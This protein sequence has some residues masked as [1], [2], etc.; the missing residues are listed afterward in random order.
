MLTLEQVR[1]QIRSDQR[2]VFGVCHL[3]SISDRGEKRVSLKISDSKPRACRSRFQ[4]PGTFARKKKKKEKCQA[5]KTVGLILT[6]DQDYKHP[7]DRDTWCIV[8]IHTAFTRFLIGTLLLFM[9]RVTW[10]SGRW[11]Q[12]QKHKSLNICCISS[13]LMM[14]NVVMWQWGLS[15]IKSD[16]EK[17]DANASCVHSI[18]KT[19]AG[20][21]FCQRRVMNIKNSTWQARRRRINVKCEGSSQNKM[22]FRYSEENGIHFNRKRLWKSGIQVR[23]GL[24][25]RDQNIRDA[26]KLNVYHWH[27]AGDCISKDTSV[28]WHVA[29]NPWW[30]TTSFDRFGVFEIIERG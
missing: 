20:F 11:S 5:L 29:V 4:S 6:L 7:N 12:S 19:F 2:K 23:I 22:P 3:L 24:I 30:M 13:L 8:L 28:I 21:L 18:T 25:Q 10:S 17:I 14:M 15:F 9:S 26:R 16:H 27:R 1:N